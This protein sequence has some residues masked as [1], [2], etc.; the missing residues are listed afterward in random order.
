[1]R[2][3]VIDCRRMKRY[4]VECGVVVLFHETRRQ[5]DERKARLN[6]CAG[7]VVLYVHE[8]RAK[9]ESSPAQARAPRWS[10]ARILIG[11]RFHRGCQGCIAE[12]SWKVFLAPG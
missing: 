5:G 7:P 4:G 1:M 11:Q 8:E 3:W 2:E 12:S 9:F 10:R 6:Q